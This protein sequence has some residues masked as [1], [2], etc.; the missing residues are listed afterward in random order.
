MHL[1]PSYI[2][3]V[4]LLAIQGIPTTLTMVVASFAFGAVF[5]F[6]IAIVVHNEVPVLSQIF[7][8]FISFMRGTPIIV[9]IFLV[10]NSLPS[11]INYVATA[12]GIPI[13]IFALNHI[14]YAIIVFS[15]SES[16]ILAEVFRA[17]LNGI[18]KG[19]IE[20]GLC[21]GLT[22]R[23]AYMRIILPQA[24]ADALPVLGNSITDL[25]KTT[26]LAF[27]MAVLDVTG[28]AKIKAAQSMNYIDAYIAIFFVYL[29]LVLVFEQLFK[30]LER[31]VRI[32]GR[33]IETS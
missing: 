9:Q 29:I 12:F 28:I 4:F 5:G 8:V 31:R 2:L 26:S 30:L 18:D 25:I 16:A 23:Q 10:Y 22:S 27:T 19:Q 13:D 33:T 11:L 1:D 7:K 17:A 32:P 15:L 6:F 21:V 20:A 24:L 3:E 14:I